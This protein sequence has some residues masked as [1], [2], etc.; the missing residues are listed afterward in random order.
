MVRAFLWVF[1][2]AILSHAAETRIAPIAGIRDFV[3]DATRSRAFVSTQSSI[4]ILNWDS[5]AID[6]TVATGIQADKIAIS[7]DGQFLYA[8]VV[9][10]GTILRYRVSNH[11]LEQSF[12]LPSGSALGLAVLP[13]KPNSIV[14]M[15]GPSSS[16]AGSAGAVADFVAIYDDGVQRPNTV[17]HPL[18]SLYARQSDGGLFGWSLGRLFRFVVTPTSL[19]GLVRATGSSFWSDKE[20]SLGRRLPL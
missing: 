18:R 16:L 6:D 19:R 14:V 3:W 9:A 13:G 8:S 2:F 17:P 11:Q 7:D 12:R 5:N 1:P 4:V 20:S 10:E 15:V